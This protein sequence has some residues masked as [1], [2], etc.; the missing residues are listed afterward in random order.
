MNDLFSKKGI[1]E[2]ERLLKNGRKIKSLEI[3]PDKEIKSAVIFLHGYGANGK[4]LIEIGNIWKKSLPGT[5]F[6]SPNA[7]F[8]C[9][10]GEEAF[11]W[12]ELTSIAPEKIGEG[13][14]KKLV[15]I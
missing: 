1:L 15:L 9:P 3:K 2:I 7:P 12:F 11:Q 13:L 5:I 8:N 6:V 4:D 10:W 14:E